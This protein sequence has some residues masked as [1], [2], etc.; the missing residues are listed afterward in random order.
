MNEV[1]NKLEDKLETRLNT[2]EIT[3]TVKMLENRLDELEKFKNTLSDLEN[4]IK[5]M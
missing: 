3:K 1:V 2:D 4:N 5:T